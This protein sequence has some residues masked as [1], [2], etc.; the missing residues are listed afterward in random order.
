MQQRISSVLWKILL[1]WGESFL[2]ACEFFK[3]A[4]D[5]LNPVP[6]FLRRKP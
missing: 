4:V 3:P 6:A 1:H 5:M 2:G